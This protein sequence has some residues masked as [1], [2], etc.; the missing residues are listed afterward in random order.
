MGLEVRDLT[1]GYSKEIPILKGVDLRA[2]DGMVTVILGPNGAGKS[3]FLKTVYGYLTPT[4]G[5]ILHDGKSISGLEPKDMLNHGIAY[6]LQ[7][8]SVFPNM[9][10]H[11]NLRL[12]AWVLRGDRRARARAFD[13]VYARFPALKERRNRFSWRSVRRRTT[14]ARTGATNHDEPQDPASRRTVCR[15]DAQTGRG[16]L[17]RDL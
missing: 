7:M 11:E 15:L 3:T 12:G 8:H 13:S 6:L 5:D 9:T 2:E 4:R 14:P 16:H 1:V 10:V 17:L